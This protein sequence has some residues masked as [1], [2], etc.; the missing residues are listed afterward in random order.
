MAANFKKIL[1]AVD[2]EA[3]SLHAAEVGIQLSCCLSAE[4]AFIHAVDP[5]LTYAP[6]IAP[7]DLVAEAE[8]DGKRVMDDIATEFPLL[9][10]KEFIRVGKPAHEILQVA[11][12]WAADVIVMGSHGRGGITRVLLGSV[13]EAVM[14]H[15]KCPVLVVRGKG[16]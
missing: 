16:E 10:A 9:S 5:S 8:G 12:E 15:A 1:I 3:V 6:G 4:I 2:G 11:N 13:A 7:A 14:R